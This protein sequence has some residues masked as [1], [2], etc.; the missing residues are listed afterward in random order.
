MNVG[1]W[2][3][4]S[5]GLTVLLLTVPAVAQTPGACPAP[6]RAPTPV[7]SIV[8]DER[9][10]R[11][12]P[13]ATSLL[14][15]E[16][17]GLESLVR[18]TPSEAPDRAALLRRLAEDYVELENAAVTE[19]KPALAQTS[20]QSAEQRYTDLKDGYPSYAA[21][22][23]VLYYLGYEYERGGDLTNARRVYF[24]LIQSRPN[25]TYIPRAYLAFGEGFF[26]DASGDPSKWALAEQ[27]YMK[28]ISFPAPNN[29]AYG[30]AWFKLAHVYWRS[31]E[32][33]KAV[34]AF[35]KA[36]AWAA[37]FAHDP[38]AATVGQAATSDFSAMRSAC[39]GV[40]L[41]SP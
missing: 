31:G 22:D 8:R 38:T 4:A 14:D 10:S 30:Y 34:L 33:A 26:T 39:P 16:L 20:R 6:T 2:R 17:Q 5:F 29:H 32:A 9:A 35:Q 21:L 7:S 37:T 36:N 41:T 3:V 19:G 25:S 40:R 18:S 23:E 1:T 11:L 13:R 12:Q 28:V 15:A 24:A 27:A